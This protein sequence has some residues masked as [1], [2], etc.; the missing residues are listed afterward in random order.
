MTRRLPDDQLSVNARNQRKYRENPENRAKDQIRSRV[1]YALRKG[2][3]VKGRCI[4]GSTQVEAHHYA[5]YDLEHALDVV[6]FCKFHHEAIHHNTPMEE[7][8]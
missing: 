7:V 4:C 2:R 3:L 5:G 1:A 6:W 8:A